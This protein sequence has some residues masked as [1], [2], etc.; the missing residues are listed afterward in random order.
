MNDRHPDRRH[1]GPGPWLGGAILICLGLIF[2]LRNLGVVDIARWWAL[3]FLIPAVVSFNEAWRQRQ[4]TG[5]FGG[6][7]IGSSVAGVIFVGLTAA[8]LFG[9]DWAV[10]WPV[11]LI[12]VGAAILSGIY[13]RRN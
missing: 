1:F 6:R 4:Q 8:F 11:I 13:W 5:S 9:L 2:L 7:A 10:F 3:V 12:L